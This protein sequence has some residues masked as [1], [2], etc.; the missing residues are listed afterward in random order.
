MA[1]NKRKSNDINPATGLPRRLRAPRETRVVSV[2]DK[3]VPTLR[4]SGLWLKRIG[5]S[6]GRKFL[7]LPDE[8]GVVVL[9][10]LKRR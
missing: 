3:S 7:V 9:A 4:L 1:H 2:S 5:F 8:T 6:P 10:L